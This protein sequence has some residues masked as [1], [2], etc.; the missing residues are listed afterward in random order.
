MDIIKSACKKLKKGGLV[1]VPTD[2]VYGLAVDASNEKAVRKL[3]D[4]KSRIPGKAISIFV[5]DLE[6]AEKYVKINQKNRNI[7]KKILPGP[8]TIVLP[9]LKRL[10]LELE[11]EKGTLGIRVIENNLISSLLK[12][13]GRP[14]TAT[15]ANLSG[16]SPHYSVVSFLKS[17]SYK[18]KR[19]IDLIVDFGKLPR[20]KPSTVVDLTTFQIKVLRKGDRDLKRQKDYITTSPEETKKI[21]RSVL[22]EIINEKNK[23][24]V[25]I[26]L[27]GE[28]GV[29]K[30][31]FVKGIGEYL[32]I[33]NIISPTFVISHEY[34]VVKHGIKKLYHLDLYRITE[35]EEFKYLGL[36]MMLRSGNVICIEWGEKSLPILNTLKKKAKIITVKM[37]YLDEKRREIK[38]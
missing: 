15:S 20:N 13:F 7:L 37:K 30:T 28:L 26:F 32:G 10:R 34:E 2:T 38:I 9:S 17:L 14:I 1:V 8:F 31:I 23:K 29:G 4:F 19:E 21:A 36:E 3:I 5:S 22:K 33:I 11:S 6:M 24:P 27:E 16:R 25:I 12:K 35:V 18:K